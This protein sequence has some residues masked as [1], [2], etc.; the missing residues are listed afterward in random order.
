MLR[1]LP[2]VAVL[3]VGLLLA[4]H[5][6][7]G[8]REGWII[9]T[10]AGVALGSVLAGQRHEAPR[11]Q[12]YAPQSGYYGRAHGQPQGFARWE[13]RREQPSHYHRPHKPRQAYRQ[14][15]QQGYQQGLR[16]AGRHSYYYAPPRW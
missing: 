10:V 2:P 9:G 15:Y 3:S 13:Q 8:E 5:T 16:D 6:Q 12:G 1:H 11:Q 4:G 14:G 7:A